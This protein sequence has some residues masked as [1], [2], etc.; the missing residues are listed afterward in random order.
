MNSSTLGPSPKSCL[1]NTPA[2]FEKRTYTYG[3]RNLQG[4]AFHPS[5]DMPI[6]A[7]HGSWHSDEIT[8]LVNSGNAGW[9]PRPNLAGRGP[10][11]DDYCG[12]SPNQ[13]D[14]LNMRRVTVRSGGWLRANSFWSKTHMA[15]AI[16]RVIRP[17]LNSYC[18][19]LCQTVWM[20]R[21]SHG[22]A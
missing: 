21:C 9:D 15:K 3:H 22:V 4:I 11:P 18:G 14:R 19:F 12:Y 16:S 5:T 7:E 6:T 2:G 17:T 8:V 1:P 10:C 13:M 20:N